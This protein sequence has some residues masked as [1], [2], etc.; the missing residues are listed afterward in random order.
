MRLSR[1]HRTPTL[2]KIQRLPKRSVPRGHAL[3]QVRAGDKSIAVHAFGC[4]NAEITPDQESSRL[5]GKRF[6][7]AIGE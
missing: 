2:A 1:R 7:S 6:A 3:N 4:A 5:Q